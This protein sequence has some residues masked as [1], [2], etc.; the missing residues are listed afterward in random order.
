MTQTTLHVY[1]LL[2]P[3]DMV[4]TI[5]TYNVLKVQ[6]M[7]KRNTTVGEREKGCQGKQYNSK[8]SALKSLY[9]QTFSYVFMCICVCMYRGT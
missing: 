2:I 7:D 1:M 6:L 8:K 9:E 3:T 4:Q 5:E